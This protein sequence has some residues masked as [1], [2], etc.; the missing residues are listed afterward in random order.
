MACRNREKAE[1]TRNEILKLH[2]EAKLDIA[3]CNGGI[4]RQQAGDA[5]ACLDARRTIQ[6]EGIDAKALNRRK[7]AYS[8]FYT[9]LRPRKLKAEHLT[10]VKL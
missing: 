5:D 7:E 6:K 9:P 1:N 4:W 10:H 8:R 3:M 2:P